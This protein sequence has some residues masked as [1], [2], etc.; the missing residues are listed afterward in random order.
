[1]ELVGLCVVAAILPLIG[2]V[3]FV[4]SWREPS[5]ANRNE[6]ALVSSAT[7]N[8]PFTERTCRIEVEA[9]GADC[10][11]LLTCP[12]TVAYT[13]DL[14]HDACKRDSKT[15]A[16]FVHEGLDVDFDARAAV[17]RRSDFTVTFE[18]K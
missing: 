11:A 5:R 2:I 6:W 4:L 18:L 10:S 9:V 17:L 3:D 13:S 1:M 16:R 7:G 15:I 14:I 12:G 8:V